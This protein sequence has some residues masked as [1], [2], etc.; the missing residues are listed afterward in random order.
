M[1]GKNSV[2]IRQFIVCVAVVH[3]GY[4]LT[5]EQD[6]DL[7]LLA[8]ACRVAE[9]VLRAVFIPMTLGLLSL[10]STTGTS[11]PDR[12]RRKRWPRSSSRRDD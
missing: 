10:A 1:V 8:L 7:A 3:E 2:R 11:A 4:A 12:W 5:R 6:R 9:G